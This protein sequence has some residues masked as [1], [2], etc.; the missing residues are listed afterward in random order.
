MRKQSFAE[1]VNSTEVMLS[2]LSANADRVAKRGIDSNFINK[3]ES[4]QSEATSINNEQEDLKARLK[5]KTQELENKIKEINKMM[6]EAKKVVKL[7]MT[8]S[9]WKAFGIEDK[10]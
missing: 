2:G 3:L 9:E 5:T 6:S 4:L 7:E 8:Q 1:I 10:R